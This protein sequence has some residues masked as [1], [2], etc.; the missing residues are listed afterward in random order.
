[1][2]R[3]R[4]VMPRYVEAGRIELALRRLRGTGPDHDV[5]VQMAADLSDD[6]AL[7]S[8]LRAVD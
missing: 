2:P 3:I 6:A 4:I 1:M 8:L 7:P 5:L